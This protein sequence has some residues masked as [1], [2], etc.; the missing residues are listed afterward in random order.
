MKRNPI[1]DLEV[2]Q[3]IT[4]TRGEYSNTMPTICAYQIAQRTGKK[5]KCRKVVGKAMTWTV[6]RIT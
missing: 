1:N 6:E 3:K 2:G 4:Q 5:F